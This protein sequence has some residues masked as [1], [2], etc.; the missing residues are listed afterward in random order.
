[1]FDVSIYRKVSFLALTVALALGVTAS[2][3]TASVWTQIGA[4]IDGEA[5]DDESGFAVSLNATGDIVAIGA[6]YNDG[7]ASE[8]G[9]VRVYRN[10]S[11]T[12]SQIGTDIDGEDEHDHSGWAVSL[13]A[14]GD[15]VAIGAPDNTPAMVFDTGHVRVYQNVG[16]TWMQ[17]GSDI[18]GEAWL[19]HSG[20]S[21]SLNA[22]GDIVAI[23]APWNN[24]VSVHAGS[25]R[26]YQNVGGTWTQIGADIDGEAEDDES[27]ASVSLNAAG[28][29]IAIGAP[30]NDG[31]AYNAGHVRVYQNVGGIWAQ[32]GTDI[33]GEAEIDQSGCS[34]SLNAAGDIIAIGAP[35]NSSAGNYAGHVRVYQNVSGTW[36]QIGADIDGYALKRLGSSVKLNTAG[37]VIVIGAPGN[38]SF[39]F[40]QVFQNVGGTWM[41]IGA[42]IDCEKVYDASG[43]SVDL[44]AAGDIVA[45]GAPFN[46]DAGDDA[47][48]TR[49]FGIA[50]APDLAIIKTVDPSGAA[51][52]D[53]ITYT[54]SFSNVG[55]VLATGVVLTDTFPIS[56]TNPTVAGSGSTIILQVGTQFVW[57]VGDMAPGGWGIIT[58]TGVLSD[59]LPNGIITNTATI[60]ATGDSTP[61]NNR[62][63]A[64][65]TVQNTP[66]HHNI[67]LPLVLRNT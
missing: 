44:N 1:M 17:I 49:V 10:V 11:G 22:V 35:S 48:H 5:E 40:T 61:G 56:V 26:V 45:I 58:V 14:T 67:F 59:V 63:G 54:L 65:V 29:I 53:A 12:W 42:N 52:G 46:D 4:D 32:I 39:S 30:N 15:I 2:A 28:N 24:D 16:N 21:V 7:A 31:A 57:N 50:F 13:N 19:E 55:T 66:A 64:G 33:D 41:Q 8:V 25:V 18:D 9:H 47:G 37:D 43:F 51:P 6:P 23:G 3:L 20:Y 38:A 27:G 60:T 34:V 62:S 36:T